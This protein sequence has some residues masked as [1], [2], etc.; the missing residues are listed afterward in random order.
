MAGVLRLTSSY[1]VARMLERDDFETRYR[2]GQSISVVEFLYPLMQAYDSVAVRA[3]VEMGGTD[4][5]FNLLVGRDVQKAYGQEPQVVFTMPL[6]EGTD[7]V[8]KMS[9]SFDNAVSLTDP[10]DEMFG[11][12]MSI[13]DELV[14]RYL[15]LLTG[16]EEPELESLGADVA[17]GGAGAAAVKR[18]L[19]REI[20]DRYHGEGRGIDAEARF[21]QVHRE[22][23]VPDDVHEVPIPAASI[24]GGRVW[25]PR[26]MVELGL[27]ASHAKARQLI[28]Q[29]GV[30]L[31]GEP[32][33]DP[34]LELDPGQL[35][36]RVLQVGRRSFLRLKAPV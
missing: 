35:A 20:V 8:R 30:R 27:A 5:T 34:G 3:D 7:G 31:D 28:Q 19:G 21:D 17:S 14:V 23:E 33:P 25:L 4:Q 9:K 12:L 2:D 16:V 1:T 29:G 11:K 6:L 10:P 24:V 15:R 18:R 22:R 26:L 13:P 32:V 36:G